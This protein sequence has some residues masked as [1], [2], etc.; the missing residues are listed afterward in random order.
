MADAGSD[1]VALAAEPNGGVA[2]LGA[3]VPQRR[4]AAVAEF[5]VLE[6]APDALVGVQ[7][8]GVAGQLLQAD[9]RGAAAGQEVLDRLG[10]GIGARSQTRSSVPGRWRSRCFR[11]RT[12]SGPQIGT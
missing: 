10:G 1:D 12:T 2:E 4:A 9:P 8:G 6:V 7:L 3:E 5:D 11:K